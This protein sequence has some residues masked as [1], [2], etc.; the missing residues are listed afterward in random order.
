MRAIS[1]AVLAVLIATPALAQA[2]L[3]EGVER[4]MT[5]GTVYSMQSDDAK[6]AGDEG[7][8]TEF[9]HRGD[10][11][12]WQARSAMEAA[13]MAPDA[14]QNVEMNFALTVGFRYG[15]GEADAMLAECLAAEDSP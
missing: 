10:A 15:A 8:A 11:L 6:A 5:C 14:I 13:G 1:L 2:D 3:P 7:G 12:I 9:F 4:L